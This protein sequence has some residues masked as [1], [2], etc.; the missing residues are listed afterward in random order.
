M[1]KY[2]IFIIFLCL[3]TAVAHAEERWALLIGIDQY[4]NDIITPLRGASHDAYTLRDVLVKQAKFPSDNVF[5]L[6]SDDKGS[7][8][9]LGN[10]L[11]KLDYIASEAKQGDVFLFFFA[12]HGVSIDEQNYLLAYESDIRPFLLPKTALSVEEL[13]HYLGKI[14]SGN[15]I[16]ILDACRNNPSSGRGDEDNLMTESFVDDVKDIQ[17]RATIYACKTG[18]RAYEWP[19]KERGIFSVVLEE[20]LNG[21]ADKDLDGKVTL[22]ETE[23]HL[24]EYVS[25][26][27][28]SEVG[29]SQDPWIDM[30]GDPRAGNLV[31]TWVPEGPTKKPESS[32]AGDTAISRDLAGNPEDYL[33]DTEL[34]QQLNTIEGPGSKEI[35]DPRLM[36]LTE[37]DKIDGWVEAS[38]ECYAENISPE[39]GHQI[40]L[41][42]ARR[43]AVKMGL[44]TGR[45][46]Y[47]NWIRS[48]G[49]FE[50]AFTD[51]SHKGLYGNIIEEKE[52]LW[53]SDEKAQ[54]GPYDPLVPIYRA[55]LRA[56]VSREVSRTNPGFIVSLRLN[57]KIFLDDEEMTLSITPT[58]DCYITVLNVLSDHTVLVLDMSAGQLSTAVPGK[59]TSTLPGEAEREAGKSLRVAL[60]EGRQRDLESIIVIATRD[61]IPFLSRNTEEL[62]P[63]IPIA[64][65]KAVL[66]ILPTY[67]NALDRLDSWLA[68][69]P[70]GRR[71]FSIQQ[72]QIK[73]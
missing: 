24:A 34:G 23:I 54:M 61:N 30:S 31:L 71:A 20:A 67:Q 68:G 38:G 46:T 10:I 40:A 43:N 45:L 7:L 73:R 50:N 19:G 6:T 14:Q 48:V 33:K 13:N 17:F 22:H 27:A 59:Q 60:S 8:P 62:R 25:K 51:L 35:I 36:P 57:N 63:D 21:K 5:C 53:T 56:K 3:V 4:S 49:E 41:E 26:R 64:G 70:L 47:R 39:E 58:Q 72:Y 15:T 12:G 28:R 52:P 11:T 9:N 65:D 16:L 66:A 69:I 29:K 55:T 44:G 2:P 32:N 18:Q 42:R 1:K 37:Q